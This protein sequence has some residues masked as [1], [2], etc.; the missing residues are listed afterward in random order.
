MK[1]GT[2]IPLMPYCLL[3]PFWF[4][5]G[6]KSKT[7]EIKTKERED[8]YHSMMYCTITGSHADSFT[9]FISWSTEKTHI[10]LRGNKVR[11]Q[12]CLIPLWSN[13]LQ[14]SS[15]SFYLRCPIPPPRQKSPRGTFHR[16]KIYHIFESITSSHMQPFSLVVIMDHM[17]HKVCLCLLDMA[18]NL[19]LM[20][21][22][23]CYSHFSTLR[24][25]VGN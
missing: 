15:F 10:R 2:Q 17:H 9:I 22:K 8:N 20:T 5:E 4:A 16:L 12:M 25:N 11:R 3:S 14:L 6:K 19:T 18:F 7:D 21:E 13:L 23:K 24:D 1:N